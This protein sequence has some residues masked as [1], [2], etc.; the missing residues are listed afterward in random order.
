MISG[1]RRSRLVL[2]ALA[3]AAP[4]VSRAS[5]PVVPQPLWQQRFGQPGLDESPGSDA[6]AVAAG[7]VF[8]AG[9]AGNANGDSDLLVQAYDATDGSLV[10][11][12]RFDTPGAVDIGVGVTTADG[13][14]FG[15]GGTHFGVGIPTLRAFDARNGRLL[16]QNQV[17]D[18]WG[19]FD[20]AVS[21][22]GSVIGVG[23]NGTWFVEAYDAATGALRWRDRFGVGSGNRANSV[24][25]HAR[26]VFVGGRARPAGLPFNWFVRAY[27]A[28]SGA[29]LWDDHEAAGSFAQV[30]AVA[31]EG[32][33]L[34]AVGRVQ[35]NLPAAPFTD[36]DWLIRTYDTKSGQRLWEDRVDTGGIDFIASPFD[37]A[38]RDGR[39]FVAGTGG[40]NCGVRTTAPDN[41]DFIVRAYAM[42]GGR[43]L[44]EDRVDRAPI[45]QSISIAANDLA[46]FAVGNGGNNCAGLEL[47]NCDL[48][49][50]AYEPGTGSVIWDDQVDVDGTDN[51][52]QAV[53]VYRDAVFVSGYVLQP[54]FTADLTVGAY[55]AIPGR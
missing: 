27:D 41:C 20:S 21:Y 33:R 7:T 3:F 36:M 45:D 4:L 5:A 2:C 55:E 43:L 6:M 22:K 1:N 42:D 12:D 28:E 23:G 39:A 17:S 30:Q 32:D 50:R 47:T 44:W 35:T 13:R 29:V 38:V 24:A 49:V 52:A 25:E 9:S 31:V 15:M 10:W 54:D 37:V 16:W 46:V 11:Q 8:L 14:V 53:R 51:F 18:V 26:R 34:I 40:R 48:L 19:T